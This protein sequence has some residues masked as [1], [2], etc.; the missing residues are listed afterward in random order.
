MRFVL[1]EMATPSEILWPSAIGGAA[2]RAQEPHLLVAVA[3]GA[4]V[5]EGA[6]AD[7]EVVA[8]RQVVDA[9][10]AG[11]AEWPASAAGSA[12]VATSTTK[13]SPK[14]LAMKAM[15]LPSGDHEARSPNAGELMDVRRQVVL[16]VATLR[17]LGVRQGGGR[18]GEERGGRDGGE[19]GAKGHADLQ[20]ARVDGHSG[21]GRRANTA[22]SSGPAPN[23]CGAPKSRRARSGAVA[24]A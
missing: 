4:D 23:T 21:C 6:R 20:S 8:V 17:A 18:G 24:L 10:E 9:Q 7:Q 11:V 14:L 13:A 2:R 1:R 15:R 3:R 12:F 16:G 19:R 22:A 5:G